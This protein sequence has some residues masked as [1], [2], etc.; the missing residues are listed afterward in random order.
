MKQN[1]LSDLKLFFSYFKPHKG[2]FILDMC[3][4]ALIALVELAFPVLTRYTINE[5]L[6]GNLYKAFFS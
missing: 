3:C 6:P 4:A 2:L 1:T 5:L